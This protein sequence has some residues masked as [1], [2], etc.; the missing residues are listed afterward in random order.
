MYTLVINDFSATEFR[1]QCLCLLIRR[2]ARRSY[3]GY[4]QACAVR[5]RDLDLSSLPE[6]IE[7]NPIISKGDLTRES[8]RRFSASCVVI[9]APMM[10]TTGEIR[11][12]NAGQ[13]FLSA[14]PAPFANP[15]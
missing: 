12:L 4:F 5:R 6:S 13:V 10:G 9:Q 1:R 2:V 8:S 15:S 3:L 7:S 14:T 11:G